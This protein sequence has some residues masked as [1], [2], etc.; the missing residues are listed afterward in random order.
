MPIEHP[1]P[2]ESSIKELYAN[3]LRCAFPGCREPLFVTRPGAVKRSLNSRMAH[4]CARREGGP[5]WN[6]LMSA[7]E[8][9]S[10]SNLVLLCIQHANEIDLPERI[11]EYPIA[12]VTDWKAKQL[13]SFDKAAGGWE[14]SD[15]EVAEVLQRSPETSVVLQ[16]HTIT[17]GGT[18]GSAPGAS[19]GGGAAIGPGAIG[20]PG[21][22]VGRIE[23][24]GGPGIAPGAGGGGGGVISI[25]AIRLV[26]GD[27]VAT[28]GRGFSSGVD[29]GD[30]GET[31]FGVGDRVL[32]RAAGGKGGLAGTGVRITT[33]R[34][35]VST[36]MLVNY[37]ELRGQLASIVGGGWQSLSVLNVPSPVVFP[38]FILFE[39]GGVDK[40]EFTA[41]VEMRDPEGI[42]RAKVSFPIAVE[43]PGDLLRIPRVCSLTAEV[44]RFGLWTIVVMTQPDRELASIGIFI[45]RAGEAEG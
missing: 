20:G 5:R 38:L 42:P 10:P 44:A 8:N 21:G 15:E 28:E 6:P 7:D 29:G 45:K 4:I 26:G 34:L 9:R 27:P 40:G 19:G 22:P 14:L 23:L 36:M 35:R 17:L 41:S 2:T 30:G 37:A 1:R 13:T 25:G 31:T 11:A 32:L 12:S 33:P 39:A 24:D 18:G 16:A 3:A 43:K